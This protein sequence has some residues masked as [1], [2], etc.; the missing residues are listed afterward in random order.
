MKKRLCH[1]NGLLVALALG[2]VLLTPPDLAGRES[3]FK[4]F[5][6]Y[7]YRDDYEH[8]PQNWGIAQAPNGLIYAANNGG[9]LEFDGV[10][11]RL[12][13][14]PGFSIARSV[15]SDD[16]GTI[17]IGGGNQIG[18]FKPDDKGSLVYRPLTEYTEKHK[19]DF[20]DMRRVYVTRDGVYF[21]DKNYLFRWAGGQMTAIIAKKAIDSSFL[22][23][24]DLFVQIKGTGLM[25]VVGDSLQLLPRGD[26][27]ADKIIYLIAPFGNGSPSQTLLIGTREGFFL[28]ER[29]TLIPFN[30]ETGDYIDKKQL[31]HGIR[32]SNGD[33]A[34]ATLRGGLVIMETTGKIKHIFDKS[35]GIQDD[36][37]KYVF[38]DREGNLWL[39]LDKGISLIEYNSPFF[40]YDE[41]YNLPGLVLTVTRHQGD[42]YAGTNRGLFVLPAQDR[43]F[44]VA[45]GLDS[46]C[47]SLLSTGSSLLVATTDGLF[48]VDGWESA[49][50]VLQGRAYSLASSTRFPGRTW[51]ATNTGLILLT[52]QNGRWQE[53]KRFADITQ[54]IRSMLEDPAGRLWLAP[55]TNGAI[56]IDFP[57]GPDRPQ[58]QVYG[59]E[60][61]FPPEEIY[62]AGAAGHVIFATTSGLFRFDEAK[63]AFIPDP[64]L[65][66]PFTGGPAGKPVFRLVEDKNRDI[67]IHSESRNYRAIP[68]ANGS[69]T[70]HSIPFK[71]IPTIQMN[72][73]YPDPDEKNT[74]FGGF[75]GLTRY[76]KTFQEDYGQAF[77]TLIRKVMAN[78]RLVFNG[79]QDKTPI[80]PRAAVPRIQYKNRNP[81]FEFAAPFFEAVNETRYR[82]F[83]EGYDKVWSDWAKDRKRNYTN[84]DSGKYTFR[85]QAQN[86]YET[87][88][89]ETTFPFRVRPPWYRTWWAYIIYF[90]GGL[91]GLFG[92]IKWRSYKLEHEKQRLESLVK[93]RTREIDEK[94]QQ[95]ETQTHQLK[96]QSEKL[97]EMDQVKSR[98]FANISHEFR[99]PL[100]LIMSPLEDMLAEKPERKEKNR[101][102]LMLQNSRQLLTRINQ[103]LDLSR[104]DSGKIKLQA[105][106]Q[107]IVLYLKGI[108]SAFQHLAQQ[109]DLHLEFQAAEE[110]ISL[111]FDAPKIE[112][113]I[114]N[115]L[116]NTVKFTPEGGKITVSI[117]RHTHQQPGDPEPG[118]FLPGF[119][120]ITV[121]DTGI[122]IPKDQLKNIFERFVQA[123]NIREDAY[124]G[125]GIGLALAKEIIAL[126]HG[127]IDVHSQEGK[128]T[129]FVIKLPLGHNHLKADE[130]VTTHLSPSPARNFSGIESLYPASQKEAPG[131]DQDEEETEVQTEEQRKN[132]ILVVEDHPDMRN[133]ICSSLS[134]LYTVVEAA[135]GKQGI[136]RAKEIIPDLII[137][138][139]MMPEKDGYELCRTLKADIDTSHIPIILLT[140]K[141]SADSACK[142]LETGADDYITKPFNTQM[143]QVRIKNLIDLRRQLQLKI[144]RQKTLLPAEIQVSSL[145]DQ[146]LKKF[147]G[148]IE[149]NLDNSDFTIDILCNKLKM[150]RS[151]LYRKIQ[152]LT[153]E[154][155]NQ[156]I[157]SYRLERG[158]QLLKQN[159]GNVTD[160]AFAV[161]FSSSTYFSKCFKDRFQQSPSDFQ[162]AQPPPG[163]PIT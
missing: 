20:V 39:G 141:A 118:K 124:K 152:A 55:T 42:F 100:T 148:I 78:D 119:V 112:E 76:D 58:V 160:V 86:V 161:G 92:I 159:F 45:A 162:A 145:D 88:G 139:I 16:D 43:A 144:Q 37:V 116:I 48:Q 73:I 85:V 9:M 130:I 82:C 40:H 97:Q 105:A 163:P 1:L 32:L 22:C 84:L 115:L 77:P 47:W 110:E 4:Y 62:L 2:L 89:Q 57:T 3:G 109:K 93:V 153:G 36:N 14:I 28:Y 41:K 27:F 52:Q 134:P 13:G 25:R 7:S 95:L 103:L 99:T 18:Y 151:S 34:L 38:E 30:T 17:Y 33:F 136:A 70:I 131:C 135:D 31:Y 91:I 24:G 102:D 10:S 21:Q 117:A 6:N 149:D 157:Q 68:G 108:A 12:F 50:K 69:Y 23:R 94:N 123:D 29:D 104:F 11:W 72:V 127:S 60:S 122:G 126:H 63:N 120:Q 90:I 46:N 137:S 5:K 150:S 79:Y 65:G 155:P 75:D 26:I 74:W 87:P 101:I 143:L 106:P 142:G 138:D 54:D 113:V 66:T 132:V 64:I 128:G 8:Q 156:F 61:G 19:W 35:S 107:N 125:T 53:D 114:N 98:F 146:F 67:W 133:Y 147:Q 96:E 121:T 154:T 49:R 158:A 81:S 129:E 71:R 15:A 111:Y 56:R 51:C 140:A 83:L 44:Q 59:E 80:S